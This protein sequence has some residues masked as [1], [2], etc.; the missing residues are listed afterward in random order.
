MADFLT[1][2]GVLLCCITLFTLT[3]V[4]MLGNV[5][6]G[7]R[8]LAVAFTWHPILMT[9]GIPVLMVLGRWSYIAGNTKDD[10]FEEVLGSR[11]H[12]HRRINT[13]A[14][15]VTMGGYI[16]ILVADIPAGHVLGYDFSTHKWQCASKVAHSIFGT[17]V[18]LGVI[19][20][21]LMGAFKLWLLESGFIKV[22]R[23]HGTVG[24]LLIAGGAINIL[25]AY[26]F[27]GWLLDFKVE[28]FWFRLP[29]IVFLLL[30]AGFG[31]MYSSPL[32]P[33]TQKLVESNQHTKPTENP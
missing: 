5:P 11:R 27:E 31:V 25:L 10:S 33:E 20:Q 8:S 26:L 4:Q 29:L 6:G 32:Q 23:A 18:V 17:L 7:K 2:F 14:T 24:K 12:L 30:C 9:L 19:V 22:F 21:A 3:M 16:A 28:T 13:I 1:S 15:L